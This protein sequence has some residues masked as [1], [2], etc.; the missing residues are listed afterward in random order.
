METVVKG[1][2]RSGTLK[3]VLRGKL[4]SYLITLPEELRLEVAKNINICGGAIASGLIGEK[5]NDY[6]VYFTNIETAKMVA[7]YYIELTGVDTKPIITDFTDING[8]TEPRLYLRT[9]S[10]GVRSI[11]VTEIAKDPA[12]RFYPRFITDNAISLTDKIQLITRFTGE[13]DKIH[14]NFDYAH[15]MCS[16]NYFTNTLNVSQEALESMLS[17][18]LVYRGSLYPIA[19]VFRMR[20]FI[21]RGWKITAGQ[22]L[23]IVFQINKLNLGNM[24]TLTDQ[25]TGVDLHYMSSLLNRLNGKSLYELEH[26]YV[27][28]VL[29]EIFGDVEET[30]MAH[31]DVS[32]SA[33]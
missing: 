31:E 20:K 27:C 28:T 21:R 24:E 29:D 13:P 32:S 19:S 30:N 18:T 7:D 15:A 4:K 33:I 14:S 16:Y 23:K 10:D 2:M 6:D 1:G 12:K 9:K 22:I 11:D 17:R 5:I 26:N 25:L 3:E 8:V